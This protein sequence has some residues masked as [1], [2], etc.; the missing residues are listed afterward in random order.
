ML[1]EPVDKS[2]IGRFWS[3]GYSKDGSGFGWFY[4]KTKQWISMEDIDNYLTKEEQEEIK[5][6]NGEIK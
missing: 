5:R 4:T 1:K 2:K 3:G 6:F